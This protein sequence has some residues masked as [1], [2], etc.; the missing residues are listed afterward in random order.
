M[1]FHLPFLGEFNVHLPKNV[2]LQNKR[3]GRVRMNQEWGNC[4]RNL[5]RLKNIIN[6]N[7]PRKRLVLFS[8]SNKKGHYWRIMGNETSIK[9]DKSK[10]TLNIPN[11]SWNSLIN[12]GLNFM[13]IHVNAISRND[14]TQEFHFKLI[15]FTLLQFGVKSNLLKLLQ[16]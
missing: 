7:S 12:N 15:E 2:H 6:F 11:I 4:E 14:V 16:N 9:V 8:Q 13:K 1:D 5:Q 3:F 10:K